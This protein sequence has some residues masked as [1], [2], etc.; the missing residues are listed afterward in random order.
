MKDFNHQ[1]GARLFN[2]DTLAQPLRRNPQ[3]NS[4]GSRWH[5]MQILRL[6]KGAKMLNE[7]I[8]FRKILYG[9]GGE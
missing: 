5:L 6:S 4:T 7:K 2:L 8:V 1:T 3:L 9:K